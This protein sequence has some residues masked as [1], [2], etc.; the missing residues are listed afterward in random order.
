L[1][2]PADF[3][4]C[5]LANFG[6]CSYSSRKARV[7]TEIAMRPIY[8]LALAVGLLALGAVAPADEK[9][10]K[11]AQ[12]L[13]ELEGTYLVIALDGKGLKFTEEDFQ[14]VPDA[15][16]RIVIKDDLI[17]SSLGGK[18]DKA[19][20]KLDPTQKP[21]HID[22]VVAREGKTET[23]YGIYKL[24]EDVLTI[25]AIERGEAK[26]RPKEFKADGKEIVMV[27]KKQKKK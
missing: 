16:R 19:T 2:Q 27:L 8:A 24:E 22:L 4:R 21:A 1:Q 23:N 5:P 25:C 15:D 18:E 6:R 3:K 12:A 14:K 17:T 9:A 20:I 13:K 11:A 10:D 26:D 7:P